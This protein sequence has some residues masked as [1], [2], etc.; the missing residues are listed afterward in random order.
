MKF[1][2]AQDTPTSPVWVVAL[3]DDNS[4]AIIGRITPNGDP[5]YPDLHILGSDHDTV[6]AEHGAAMLDLAEWIEDTL[7]VTPNAPIIELKGEV[8]FFIAAHTPSHIPGSDDNMLIIR[9][10]HTHKSIKEKP[11]VDYIAKI[12]ASNVTILYKTDLWNPGNQVIIQDCKQ[13]AEKYAKAE[14]ELHQK[15]AAE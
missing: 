13:M 7:G 1:Y 15:L 12:D 14:I 4:P 5:D 10:V 6:M 11:M 9:L 2:T 8:P 3:K